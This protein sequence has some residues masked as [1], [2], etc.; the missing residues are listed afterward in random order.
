MGMSALTMLVLGDSILWGQGVHDSYKFSAEVEQ[1]LAA[2]VN[3]RVTRKVFAHSGAVIA[4]GSAADEAYMLNVLKDESPDLKGEVPSSYPSITKQVELATTWLAATGLRPEEV[5]L[6]LLDG[7]SND[8][9]VVHLVDPLQRGET[10]YAEAQRCCGQPMQH[11]LR[12]VLAAFPNAGVVVTGYYPIVSNL[13]K[14]RGIKPLLDA[15]N[16]VGFWEK[17]VA[18]A[19]GAV[20]LSL[21]FQLLRHKLANLSTAW[22]DGST[23]ALREA[24]EAVNAQITHPDRPRVLFAP[25]SF[26]PENCME[27][28]NTFIWKGDDDDL[29]AERSAYAER[30][31]GQDVRAVVELPIASLGHPNRKG[32]HAYAQAIIK[33]LALWTTSGAW[34]PAIAAPAARLKVSIEG[35]PTV[36]PGQK[37]PAQVTV[38]AVDAQTNQPVSGVVEIT[39]HDDTQS[40]R[41]PLNQPFTG[42]FHAHEL[43]IFRKGKIPTTTRIRVLADGYDPVWVRW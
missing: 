34:N 11:L 32:A 4:P 13:S 35:A 9:D 6:I 30:A 42:E 3:P 28:G 8:L 31:R 29:C 38:H 12:S 22:A 41:Y 36:L 39:N 2:H 37:V 23:L 33:A 16:V 24:V 14:P 7:G 20:L 43:K 17:F 1:W 5:H 18:T 27:A 25:V 19:L 15:F 40:D 26:Q 10:L 21:R